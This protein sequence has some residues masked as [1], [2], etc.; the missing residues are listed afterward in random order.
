MGTLESRFNIQ[1]SI[2]PKHPKLRYVLLNLVGLWMDLCMVYQQQTHW[3]TM[4]ILS[5]FMTTQMINE[6]IESQYSE[7]ST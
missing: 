1:F 2:P 6:V 7:W 5:L 3:F 4:T